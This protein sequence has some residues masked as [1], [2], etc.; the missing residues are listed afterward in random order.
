MVGIT[1]IKTTGYTSGITIY[2]CEDYSG[3][4]FK[5]KCIESKENCRMLVSKIFI[6]K[7]QTSYKNIMT[8]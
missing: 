6:E 2:K 3:C 7:C 8:E 5:E 4:I 1:N